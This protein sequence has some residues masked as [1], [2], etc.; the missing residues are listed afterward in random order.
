[1][2]VLSFLA[3]MLLIVAGCSES[4]EP[5]AVSASTDKPATMASMPAYP[6]I[7]SLSVMQANGESNSTA[8]VRETLARIDR[9]ASLNAFI[10]V[11]AESAE[12]RAGELDRMR[13]S[14]K[15]PGPLHGIPL[16][17]KDNIHVAGMLN[18][19][20]T[21]G[22]KDFVPAVSNE[23]VQRLEAAGA[24]I[25]GKTNLHELAF[26]I[27]SNNAAFGAV[28]NPYDENLIP[29]GSSGGTAAAVSAGIVAAGLGTDT[30]GSVRIPPALTGI[31]GFRPSMGRYPSTAVTPI[32]HTRDTVG[33]LSRTVGDLIVLDKVIAGDQ[34]PVSDIRPD[35]IRLGVPR[36]YFYHDLDEQTAAVMDATLNQLA[37]AGVQLI[38]A[39]IPDID[40]LMTASA[41]PIAFYE[42][43]RDL[44]TYLQDFN[45]GVSFAQLTEAAASPDVKGVLQLVSGE[46]KTSDEV[47]AT[48]MEARAQ[49]RKNYQQYFADQQLDAIV[50]PT[51]ILPARPIQGS[52]ETV[53][54]NGEQVP[55]LPS[56]IHNTDPASIAALPGISLPVGLTTSGLPV[57]ME[58]D[59]PE[60]SDRRLL[61]VARV[62]E[63]I[64]DF[65]GRPA[66]KRP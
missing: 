24:I 52:L 42:V 31:V 53:W 7:D 55:T 48:A 58:I 54:L 8:I 37:E 41:F 10:T 27:T 63:E 26:G 23:V 1:M 6:D 19:A 25:I 9:F 43:L 18:T 15:A 22:L 12:Q 2:R 34:K 65:S 14:G 38:E 4:T 61:A 11:A 50:F 35:E 46:N 47:Y 28:R 29:G 44:T 36:Q 40:S 39:D 20:G 66:Q 56:Y 32:S 57:G 33:L 45:T 17:V 60:Q 16:V 49:L 59:G 62:L 3:A 64:I 5:V 13:D 21:P 51:T 30:G